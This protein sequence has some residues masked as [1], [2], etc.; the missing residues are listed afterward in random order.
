VFDV[1]TTGDKG[2]AKAYLLQQDLRLHGS[3]VQ[4]M[5]DKEGTRSGEPLV[6]TAIVL[7]M[8]SGRPTPTGS[9]TFLI[10]GVAAG[11][12]VKLDERGQARLTTNRLGAGAHKIR[13]AYTSG[14]GENGYHSSASPNLL[15]TVKKGSR[16][17]S[18]TIWIWII[19][20]L[21]AIAAYIAYAYW[22]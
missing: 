19:L 15:H 2:F 18:W 3:T 6:V 16:F 5:G 14:G 21:I 1:A 9:I 4:I 7:P 12:P 10:D 20:V 11:A 22:S 8:T 17:G 13:A